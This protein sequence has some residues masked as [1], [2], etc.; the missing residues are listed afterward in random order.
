MRNFCR[1][2]LLAAAV[3]SVCEETAIEEGSAADLKAPLL[4]KNDI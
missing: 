4:P 2:L 1:N 3:A